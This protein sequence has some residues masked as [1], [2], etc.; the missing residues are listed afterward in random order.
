M[1]AIPEVDS[2][3]RELLCRLRDAVDASDM[4]QIQILTQAFDTAVRGLAEQQPAVPAPVLHELVSDLAALLDKC[5]THRETLKNKILKSRTGRHGLAA[6][7][8]VH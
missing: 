1:P 6:Y 7:R 8:T 3:A 2:E 4:Q 5:R